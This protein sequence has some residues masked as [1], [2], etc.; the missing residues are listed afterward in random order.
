MAIVRVIDSRS[1][2]STQDFEDDVPKDT[3][4]PYDGID[5]VEINSN[6]FIFQSADENGS[7]QP[8]TLR[9]IFTGQFNGNTLQTVDGSVESW[10]RAYSSDGVNFTEYQEITGIA[11]PL[12]QLIETGWTNL[13]SGVDTL[14]GGNYTDT[15]YS[16]GG[17]DI[18]QGGGG[19][20]TLHGGA[21]ND[22]LLAGGGND[23]VMGGQGNDEMG[24]GQ[25]NDT[26]QGAL[27]N[28]T[29]KGALGNDVLRG[30]AGD[31]QI[32][33]GDGYDII[34]GGLGDDTLRGGLGA[35]DFVFASGSGHDVILD[36]G[37]GGVDRILLQTGTSYQTAVAGGNL[38]ATFGDGSSL[39]LVGVTTTE[40]I[41]F[42]FY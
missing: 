21:G 34:T 23:H 17:D 37:A 19:E 40:S 9:N 33:G 28:D 5:L 39:T 22:Q 16:Y 12:R 41:S 31:D 32:S 38:I 35:D 4:D 2:M 7:G 20:D 30:G 29:L 14:I 26:L 1:Y 42:V 13:L 36:A 10:V 6:K 3:E 18:V 15:L 11:L 24:A 25:G 8:V 27:G